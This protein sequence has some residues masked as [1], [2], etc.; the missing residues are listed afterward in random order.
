MVI[1]CFPITKKGVCYIRTSRQDSAIMYNSN[2][3]FHVGQAKV[4]L[5]LC[6]YGESKKTENY[7]SNINMGINMLPYFSP[8]NSE[9]SIIILKKGCYISLCQVVY[10]NKDD[11]V[12]VVA[13]GVTL[14]EALAAA[15]HLKKGTMQKN[16]T[17]WVENTLIIGKDY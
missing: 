16:T 9:F 11:Q 15:E 6:H 17:S 4:R 13:A 2:E 12:T 5:S 8:V 7:F 14:H 1:L 10:Q 3:D